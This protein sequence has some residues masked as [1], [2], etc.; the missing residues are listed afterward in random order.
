MAI[1][2]HPRAA[3]AVPW[4]SAQAAALQS[5]LAHTLPLGIANV[6][7]V[8]AVVL[9]ADGRVLYS[10]LARQA[11]TPASAL[12]VLVAST[13]LHDLGP[14][15]RFQTRLAAAGSPDSSGQLRVPMWLIGS[16]DPTLRYKDLR[17]GVQVVRAGGVR[18]LPRV[19][20]DAH[21]I[22]GPELNPFWNQNDA[23]EDYQVAT[24]GISLDE[25]TVEF[26]FEGTSPRKPARVYIEPPSSAV[27]WSGTVST[28]AA[29]DGI[30]VEPV[31]PNAFIVSG[32]LGAGGKRT[33]YLP[34][35]GLP[36]YTGAVVDRMLKDRG[37][38]VASRAGTGIAPEGLRTYWARRSPP[39]RAI[40]KHMLVHSDNHFAEQLLRYLGRS[41]GGNAV[42]S[43]GVAAEVRFLRDARIPTDGLVLHDASGLAHADRISALT[44]ALILRY[45]QGAGDQLYPLLARGGIDGTLRSYHFQASRGRVRAKSGHLDDVDALVGYVDT[46]K[47]GRLTF[48]FLIEGTRYVDD[49]VVAALDR[50]ATL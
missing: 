28:S 12:K 44:L 2:T 15:M 14:E 6:R 8:S 48:A 1:R 36:S 16:G 3:A 13:A 50:L 30:D 33:K 27:R 7:R 49:A 23:N 10:Q 37:V 42:D 22:S 40:V 43:A 46:R 38:A 39:L 45:A 31:A 25:D 34:V 24:S 35:H 21:A 18:S 17:R 4:T 20:V 41:T 5:V 47:H 26:H 19:M 9:A 32:Y 11:L 29:G